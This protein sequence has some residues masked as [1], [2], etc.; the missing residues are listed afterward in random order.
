MNYWNIAERSEPN[1]S[2]YIYI[3][4]PFWGEGNKDV[5]SMIYEK[6]ALK[7]NNSKVLLSS[8]KIYYL[9]SIHH[10]TSYFRC[11]EVISTS[12]VAM[13]PYKHF[14]V[15]RSKIHE[16]IWTEMSIH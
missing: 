8:Q 14:N 11:Q 4:T 7:H 1:Q 5:A 10:N 12:Q 3:T 2:F 13:I 6:W 9:K 15:T 16:Y